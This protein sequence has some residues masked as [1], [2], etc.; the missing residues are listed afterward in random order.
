MTT[1]GGSNDEGVLFLFDP[2]NHVYSKLVNFGGGYGSHPNGDLMQAP[3]GKLYGM[4][5]P[6][7]SNDKGVLFSFDLLTNTYLKLFDFDGES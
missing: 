1:N 7:G 6:G 5:N 3:N 2:V 4:T